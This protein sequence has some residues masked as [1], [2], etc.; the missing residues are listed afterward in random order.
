MGAWQPLQAQY[1]KITPTL[2]IQ[3]LPNFSATGGDPL[4][5][6]ADDPISYT[7]VRKGLSKDRVQD[8]LR[9]INWCSAPFGTQEFL[10][11]EY[12]V[13][14]K[15]WKR[16]PGGVPAKED[17]AFKEIQNQYFFISGR[18]PVV[19]PYPETP[20]Y[21]K[22]MLGYSNTNVKYLEKDP[23]DG[24]K[25]EFPAR[26]KSNKVPTE[27]KLTDVVRGRRPLGDI[28]TIVSEWRANGGDEARDFLARA[29]SDAGR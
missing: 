12:G 25:L 8:L 16:G 21:V 4:I 17:L 13:E 24:L 11:R 18:N 20:N 6:R 1:Q 14:G 3:P 22:D 28:D 27:D 9:V 10:L 7:F 19:Q 5:W 15:H 29:L 26:F 2:N 23:W